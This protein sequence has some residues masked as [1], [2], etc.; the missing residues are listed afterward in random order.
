MS[1][2]HDLQNWSAASLN[3][4]LDFYEV[5]F[6][7]KVTAI[8]IIFLARVA[9]SCLFFIF[10]YLSQSKQLAGINN[11]CIVRSLKCHTNKRYYWD[12]LNLPIEST[13]SF[14]LRILV[15]ELGYFTQAMYIHLLMILT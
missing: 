2:L 14:L 10:F 12:Y 15:Y 3:L 13:K 11:V 6:Y 9:L 1:S 8:V 4:N 5:T 7:P